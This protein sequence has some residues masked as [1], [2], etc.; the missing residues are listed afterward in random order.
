MTR[1]I[2]KSFRSP[3]EIREIPKGKVE[4]LDLDGFA[5]G[6]V[7]YE[8]GFR[9]SECL[10]DSVGTE[11]CEAKHIGYVLAGRLRV[12]MADGTET[13]VAAGDAYIV[14]PGHDGWVVGDE[15]FE[16]LDFSQDIK[17]YAAR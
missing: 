1:S 8:P 10:R 15:P 16:A 13:E 3:D 9:W 7:R 11:F 4:V 17:G 12:R 5:C 6:K 14:P 2:A